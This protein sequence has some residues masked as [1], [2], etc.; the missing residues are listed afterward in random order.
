MKNGIK[1]IDYWDI[2][3][4]Y[5][6][7]VLNGYHIE[8]LDFYREIEDLSVEQFSINLVY[9]YRQDKQAKRRLGRIKPLQS[10]TVRE[11]QKEHDK[12][13]P[14][15]RFNLSLTKGKTTVYHQCYADVVML[16]MRN[17]F[18]SR[19][20]I[21]LPKEQEETLLFSI[22]AKYGY[23]PE[24]KNAIKDIYEKVVPTNSKLKKT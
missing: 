11:F 20:N 17:M 2:D 10:L 8:Y 23:T 13:H 4:K 16:L 19:C 5:I 15:D 24:D 18:S 9:D 12:F 6:S 1:R 21:T 7:E 22:A 14:L 3:A